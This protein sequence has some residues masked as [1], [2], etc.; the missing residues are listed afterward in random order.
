[1]W[2]IEDIKEGLNRLIEFIKEVKYG[3]DN[4]FK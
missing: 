3:T 1:M 2:S 4:I